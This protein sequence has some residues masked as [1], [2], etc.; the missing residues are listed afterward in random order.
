MNNVIR[1]LQFESVS[2]KYRHTKFWSL[3]DVSLK[4]ENGK[5]SGL[6]GLNGA[7]KTTAIKIAASLIEQTEGDIICDN[8]SLSNDKDYIRNIGTVL[9]S[10]S[11]D[12]VQTAYNQLSYYCGLYGLSKKEQRDKSSELLKT[13]GLYDNRN[14]RLSAY[15]HGMKKRFMIASALINDPSTLLFDETFNGLDPD[16]CRYLKAFIKDSV[17]KGKSILIS[18]HSL[19]ELAEIADKIYVLHKGEIVRILEHSDFIGNKPNGLRIMI[20]PIDDRAV[21]LIREF[22]ETSA[23]GNEAVLLNSDIN[24]ETVAR[25]RKILEKNGYKILDIRKNFKKL[26]EIFFEIISL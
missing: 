16:G 9:D 6:I 5:V 26:E 11:F 3:K 24:E 7:G 13:V 25:I 23:D 15:S 17:K 20:D 19:T 1:M 21:R 2:K 22:G 4:A 18:S 12:P 14:R 10:D 8:L